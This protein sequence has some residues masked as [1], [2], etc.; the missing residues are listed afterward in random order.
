[1][2]CPTTAD[3]VDAVL[4]DVTAFWSS[5]HR[6]YA[7]HE[8]RTAR[9]RV[10][11]VVVPERDVAG[12][13]STYDPTTGLFTHRRCGARVTVTCPDCGQR[14]ELA[15]WNLNRLEGRPEDKAR[16]LAR[17]RRCSSRR[18]AASNRGARMEDLILQRIDHMR[19][20]GPET[21]GDRTLLDSL[22]RCKLEPGSAGFLIERANEP[23]VADALA[24]LRAEALFRNIG[25]GDV[26]TGRLALLDGNRKRALNRAGHAG[27]PHPGKA[28]AS[29]SAAGLAGSWFR[30]PLCWLLVYRTQH[31]SA[32]RSG[33]LAWH[34][35]CLQAW[36]RTAK[37]HDWRTQQAFAVR[38]ALE[39]PP[40]PL[41]PAP[42]PPRGQISNGE[43]AARYAAPGA[44]GAYAA[45]MACRGGRSISDTARSLGIAR[46]SVQDRLESICSSMPASWDLVFGPTTKGNATRQEFYPLPASNKGQVAAAQRMKKLGINPDVIERVTGVAL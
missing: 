41:P 42:A 32:L 11:D 39:S 45:L 17:C 12:R 3:A 26:E 22:R 36:L 38:H 20:R 46:Q 16:S 9:C 2:V 34:R 28:R 24:L 31:K 27:P 1:M 25:H 43:P 23:G 37:A 13:N 15:R 4:R 30:C 40:F 19:A 35:P 10:C 21:E 8:G 5:A 18:A 14:R 33:R 7:V 29:V 6:T 44:A